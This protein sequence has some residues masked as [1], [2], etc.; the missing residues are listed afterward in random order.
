MVKRT[1]IK[2]KLLVFS[3]VFYP[4]ILVLGGLAFF[5][6]MRRGAYNNAN[7]E[8][9]RKVELEKTILETF[10][11]SE[12]N[13]VLKMADSPLIKRYFLNPADSEVEKIAY[14]EFSSYRN[15]FSS[16]TIFWANDVDKILWFNESAAN[17]IDPENPQ[18]YWYNMTLY[19]TQ[20]YN[21]NIN[22]N[23]EIDK[24]FL[25]INAPVFDSGLKAIGIVGT[26]IDITEF[27]GPLYMDLPDS[28]E[29]YFFNKLYEITC[30]HDTGLIL[31]KT[32]V[33]E[34]L[35]ETGKEI[36]NMAKERLISN[37]VK[38]IQSFNVKNNA[39]AIGE[40]PALDWYAAVIRP[41]TITDIL[42]G[43][44]TILFAVMMI[45]ILAIFIIYY[46]FITRIIHRTTDT[47]G[48]IFSSLEENDLSVQINVQTHDEIGDMILS[49]GGFLEKIRTAFALFSQEASTVSAAVNELSS[50]AKEVTATANEQSASVAE[51]VSTMENNKNLSMQVSVNT[52]EVA[53]MAEKTQRLS[54]HGADLHEANEDMM[55]D[56]R[57]Q[58]AKIV[59]EI[60]N[61]NDV[62][63]RIDE[64]V[65]GIDTI[66]D[67]TKLI[68][69]NAA[70]E[71]S[72]SGEAGLRFAVVA[73][74]IRRFADNV[75]ETALE[76]KDRITELQSV[77]NTLISEADIGSRAIDL[78]YNRMV[79][80]KEVYKD[81]VNVSENVAVSSQ[82]ISSL[83]K[84][85]EHASE[86]VFATLKEISLGVRQFVSAT[87]ST[88]VTVD[89]LNVLSI[90]LAQTLA[91]YRIS[92]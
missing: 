88:S 2:R 83:S 7:Y 36:I 89:K 49:L 6:S 61:L 16:K 52:S 92:G 74:E 77:S 90:E 45:T 55:S 66:A 60:K 64:S 75:V 79:E 25:W 76:I 48:H 15:T 80:Q 21:F 12:I 81:I 39:V 62:L 44:I 46:L 3:F 33:D 28:D 10:V 29:L 42:S 71:A 69:F 1:S 38:E 14:N 41:I 59:E 68:A 87:A 4:L 18:E 84:Q 20:S 86:Q 35:G 53:K 67:K 11:K 47:A 37:N 23:A 63:S 65:Q 17:V 32:K 85:Q 73:S 54:R 13:I 34:A 30:S 43:A 57:D 9:T 5:I 78:G 58:N 24:T 91:K 8:L 22:Y 50:S 51:I 27:T 26:G 40:V 19:D 31:N 82:Q 70:L 72:S 56:I